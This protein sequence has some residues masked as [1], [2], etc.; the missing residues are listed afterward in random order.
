MKE[1]DIRKKVYIWGAGNYLELVYSAINKNKCLVKGIIDRDKNKHGKV[2]IGELPIENP[3]NLNKVK[4]DLIL[5]SAKNYYPILNECRSMGID[6]NKIIVFWNLNNESPFV[7]YKVKRIYELEK[8][9][10]KYKVRLENLPYELGVEESICMKSAEELMHLIIKRGFSLCRFGDGE[11][12]IMRKKERLWYQE[13]NINLTIRLQ[14]VLNTKDPNIII[15]VANNFG[16]LSCY[17]ERS[18]DG[19]RQYLSGGR[20]KEILKLLD[21]N[22]IYYDAYVTRPYYMYKDKSYADK[23]FALFKKVWDNRHLLIVEGKYTK[24]GVRNDLFKNT[25]SIRRI[26]CPDRNAFNKYE[27]ILYTV[28]KVVKKGELVL[29]SLGPTATVLAY[30]L[31]RCGIQALDIG[32][33][34]NEYEWFLRKTDD[35]VEIPGKVVAELNWCHQPIE[36]E[37]D[38]DYIRQIIK[39]IE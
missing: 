14:E 16:N 27:E 39:R 21:K 7:D 15:A 36:M 25:N 29:I 17:T 3:D 11:L 31:A 24:N 8:E 37:E 34:D 18:A 2:M 35:R 32:Q 1:I 12:E 23:I 10:E 33:I 6:E 38:C 30:D 20:R 19:I 28:K 13:V 5:I 26:L 4:F 22:R 9:L